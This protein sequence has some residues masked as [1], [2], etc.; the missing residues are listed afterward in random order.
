MV[1]K[2]FDLRKKAG[3]CTLILFILAIHPFHADAQEGW[4]DTLRAA[5][6]TDAMRISR[7]IVSLEADIEAV[8]AVVTPITDPADDQGYLVF[9]SISEEYERYH[10]ESFYFQDL[11]ESSILSDIYIRDNVFSNID[12]GLGIFGAKAETKMVW[13]E[14]PSIYGRKQGYVR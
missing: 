13:S 2:T 10:M 6:K 11:Y 1:G 8:R 14:K 3:I 7:D 9:A 5:V 4:T 12:N